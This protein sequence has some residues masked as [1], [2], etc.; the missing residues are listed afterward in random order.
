MPYKIE[1][2]CKNVP[3]NSHLQ[4][5]ILVS[6][7]TLASMGWKESDYDFTDS[8][9]WHYVRLKPGTDYKAFNAKLA[10]FSQKHFEGSKVSGSDEKF[11]LT[12]TFKSTSVF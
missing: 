2:I 11:Y 7:K 4:F 6:Y 5:R 10:A 8:D 1:G 9:F 3:E 12:A